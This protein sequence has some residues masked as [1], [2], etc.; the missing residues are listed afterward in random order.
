MINNLNNIEKILCLLIS[1][2]LYLTV[3]III[4]SIFFRFPLLFLISIM[5]SYYFY[6]KR[7]R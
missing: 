6:K 2:A 3:I 4:L 7:A 5:L 1:F